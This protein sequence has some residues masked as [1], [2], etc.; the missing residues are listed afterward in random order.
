M[1]GG[2]L[3]TSN[4]FVNP[5]SQILFHSGTVQAGSSQVANN[6]PFIVGNGT[7]PAAYQLQGGN[8]SFSRG[9]R[10][11]NSGLLSGSGNITAS[12]TN[13]GA[14]APG[15]SPARLTIAGA[16]VLSNS[17]DLR[18]EI[19]GYTPTAQFDTMSVTGTVLLGG[20][21]SVSL[22][23]NFQSLM[24][25][26]ASFTLLT[27]TTP[28]TGAFTNVASGGTLTTT[29]GAARFTVLYAGSSTL[30]LTALQ[31]L[32]ADND[33]MP[34][35]W[36]DLYGLNKNSAADAALDTDADGASNLNEFRAGTNPT[37]AA[38]VF[39]VSLAQQG[40]NNV[41]IT[42][43]TV[44]GKSYRVQTNVVQNGGGISTNF[45]DFSTLVTVPG[46]GESTTN[47]VLVGAVTNTPTGY[48]RIRL[49][50]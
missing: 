11:S 8:H 37:N 4:L 22:S 49:S 5:T 6:Q 21:L 26:G 3:I 50:P 16:L 41:R 48:Y 43:T 15:S 10:I 31:I 34:N 13:A 12:V 44:G 17:S 33:G 32:D 39:R 47:I 20:K 45:A 40:I 29:D 46:S 42:W 25:N 24:T 38:S 9:L 35:W 14:V 28:L 1:A 30:Q 23:N 2:T 36:E 7:S 27:S 18:F 19:A